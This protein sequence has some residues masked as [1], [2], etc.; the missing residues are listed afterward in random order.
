VLEGVKTPLSDGGRIP[1]GR[2][3]MDLILGGREGRLE[4]S[5][6]DSKK[7]QLGGELV[8]NLSQQR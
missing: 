5:G 8:G 2:T 3:F 1:R 6:E 7:F 4:E